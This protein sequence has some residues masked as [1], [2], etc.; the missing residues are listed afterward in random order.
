MAGQANQG[1]IISRIVDRLASHVPGQ[2]EATV[3]L[4]A[5]TLPQ[6]QPP[7]D[8]FIAVT[9][10]P[11]TFDLF[12]GSGLHQV[13][14]FCSFT[15]S[16]FSRALLDRAD[17]EK[18]AL[19]SEQYGVLAVAERNILRALLHDETDPRKSFNPAKG[20]GESNMLLREQITPVGFSAPESL[21]SDGGINYLRISIEFTYAFDWDLGVE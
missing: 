4:C 10:N 20:P 13:S 5:D 15:V 2:S 12:G 3:L 18:A 6:T 16:V 8:T 17:S 9:I 11:G 21:E 1:D 14:K 19:V 7:G